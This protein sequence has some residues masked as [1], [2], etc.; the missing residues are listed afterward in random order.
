MQKLVVGQATLV[1]E[2]PPSWV[3]ALQPADPVLVSTTTAPDAP[4][5]TQNALPGAQETAFSAPAALVVAECQEPLVVGAVLTFAFMPA[6][7]THSPPDGQDTP[8]C[9]PSPWPVEF[10]APSDG[11]AKAGV[12]AAASRHASRAAPTATRM[13]VGPALR[14]PSLDV[15]P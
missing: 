7:E 8:V 14:V 13:R 5:A 11:L 9:A 4:T 6:T 12:A 10:H 15:I 1:R 2:L 3:E